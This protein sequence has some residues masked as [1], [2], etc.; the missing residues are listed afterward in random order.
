M[1]FDFN[2]IRAAVKILN[3]GHL[4]PRGLQQDLWCRPLSSTG[5]RLTFSCSMDPFSGLEKANG[6]LVRIMF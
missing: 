6:S 4:T 3:L 1:D 5:D 2:I